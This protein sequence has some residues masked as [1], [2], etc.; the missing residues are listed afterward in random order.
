MNSPNKKSTSKA[1]S[2]VTIR[3]NPD[4]TFSSTNVQ[5]A[6]GTYLK[7]IQHFKVWSGT[8]LFLQL[9]LRRVDR[10]V[11]P[12]IRYPIS[13]RKGTS[14]QQAFYQVFLY[15]E[16]EILFPENPKVIIDGGANVGLFTILMKNRFPTAKFVCIEP[17][18]ENFQQLQKNVKAYE[19]VYCENCGLWPMV[20][21]LKVW[22]KFNIGK[23][24]MVVEEN[25][26]DWNVKAISIDYLMK[27]YGIEVIDVLKLD[28]EASEK[29]LFTT[30]YHNWLAKTK[31]IIIELHDTM[32]EGCARQ[33]FETINKVYSSYELSIKG[34][35]IILVNKNFTQ[36]KQ[37]FERL[38][39]VS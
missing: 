31:M 6:I 29:E 19:D 8:R 30:N 28:I 1:F 3:Q 24:A 39:S 7:L 15:K 36:T 18:V 23:W 11:I 4:Q 22:D 16:Y 17:D 34:E 35:N 38:S 20:T 14:D 37:A 13:L 12:N 27:K 2:E 21:N 5:K 32:K 26:D 33:F 9:L 10:L 25:M